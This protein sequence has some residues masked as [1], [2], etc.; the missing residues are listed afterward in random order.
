MRLNFKFLYFI[1]Y[2]NKIIELIKILQIISL[3]PSSSHKVELRLIY[4]P[5]DDS[6]SALN[7]NILLVARW[8]YLYSHKLNDLLRIYC[9]DLNL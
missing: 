3:A 9:D 5:I 8:H 1:V 7:I 4:S 2:R 6:R